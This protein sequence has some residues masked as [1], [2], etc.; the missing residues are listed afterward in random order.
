MLVMSPA[1]Y[2]T[3]LV[4]DWILGDV[5]PLP[6][7]PWWWH[8]HPILFRK[9]GT[10]ISVASSFI[11]LRSQRATTT[12]P[13]QRYVQPVLRLLLIIPCTLTRWASSKVLWHTETRLLRWSKYTSMVYLWLTLSLYDRSWR[14][15]TKCLCWRTR[16]CLISIPSAQS[17]TVA[18]GSKLWGWCYLQS[19]N[20]TFDDVVEYLCIMRREI[21][22][23]GCCSS[24]FEW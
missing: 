3:S 5:C 20:N 6:C 15:W 23:L 10:S 17:T 2:P 4:L 9:L 22:L 11:S 18:I 21:I 24:R 7:D 8:V 13:L 12:L 19:L 14:R 1:A 16:L